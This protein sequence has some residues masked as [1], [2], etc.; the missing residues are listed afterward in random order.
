MKGF[1][2]LA[3]AVA[4]LST[5]VNVTASD[6]SN[7]DIDAKNGSGSVS[8]VVLANELAKLGLEQ[9][10]PMF[11]ITAAK[12]KKSLPSSKLDIEKT[13][14]NSKKD[15][16]KTTGIDLSAEALLLQA[17]SLSGSN[18]ALILLAEEVETTASRGRVKGP[19]VH[20]D[21][22]SKGSYDLYT[23]AFQGNEL[24]EVGVLGDGD[25]DL[26]LYIYDESG[27]RVC[28]DADSTD[29]MYCRWTPKRTGDFTIKIKN[30]GDVYNQYD[31]LVE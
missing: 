21:R 7:V 23:M 1:K 11:L 13:T 15:S 9:Q 5:S 25:T 16:D 24:A 18:A 30:L 31:L 20:T 17:K 4:I 26:D 19:A 28:S 3:I 12:I 8:Q 29:T 10:D 14:G 22:V 6:T 2:K 27:N